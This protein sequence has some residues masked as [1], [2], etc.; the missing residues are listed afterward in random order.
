[1]PRE[2]VAEHTPWTHYLGTWIGLLALTSLTFGLSYVHTGEWELPIAILIAVAKS[3]LVLLFFMHLVEQKFINGF[4]VI[5]A[6]GLLA[7]LVALLSAD[8]ATRRTFPRT[9]L[10][11]LLPLPPKLAPPPPGG[12]A[13]PPPW[14][15]PSDF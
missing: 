2:N 6:V 8:I 13:G 1:M 7:L 3:L 10:P 5:V 15:P 11:E 12:T 4:V 9:P 14:P